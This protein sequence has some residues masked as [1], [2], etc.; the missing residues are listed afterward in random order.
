MPFF[1]RPLK[2]SAQKPHD[3][4]NRLVEGPL[5]RVSP[6]H[7]GR[8]YSLPGTNGLYQVHFRSA[9]SNRDHQM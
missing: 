7:L 3:H 5:A 1:L 2:I 8:T 9:N 4:S 6:T